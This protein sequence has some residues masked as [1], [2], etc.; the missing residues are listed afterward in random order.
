MDYA[1]FILRRERLERNWSQ[2]GLCKGICT[3]SYL[4]KIE[5]G[6]ADPVPELI[7]KL[8]SQLDIEWH[9]AD[10]Q[11]T[12]FIENVW[13]T[14]LSFSLSID[15][16]FEHIFEDIDADRYLYSPLG[17]DFLILNSISSDA[18][19]PLDEALEVCLNTRQL[20]FQ[21][22][23]QKRF[24][25]ALRLFPCPYL[26]VMTGREYYSCG[27]MPTALENLQKGYQLAADE[28]YPH[29]ML[30]A[31][32]LMGNCYSNHRDIPAMQRH[33]QIARRL[34]KALN[35]DSSLQTI[36]YN[37]AS[38]WLE[39]GAYDK[40]LTYFAS[41]AKPSRMDLHKLAVCC[42]KLGRTEDALAA[43]RQAK[44]APPYEWMPENLDE[45]I[46][47]LVEYRLTHPDYL[48]DENYGCILTDTFTRMTAHLP[49]GYANFHLPW[50]LEWYESNR[51][52]RQAYLLMCDFPELRNNAAFKA[53]R[54]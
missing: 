31:Q 13:E 15:G 33:Y 10:G 54:P 44:T 1:G 22:Y 50:M 14:L 43:I 23:L 21:R 45:R 47:E 41:I 26:Y 40:A 7:Q 5:Q 6:K 8:M 28:G 34:A 27:N 12:A 20:A 36:D 29:L 9:D 24:D 53:K 38:T 4:S 37:T 25:E 19:L 35:D 18:Y 2:E 30:L 11:M 51:R 52:Y 32:M 48:N 42:E 16:Q 49:S 39:A 46:L 17:A 3:V